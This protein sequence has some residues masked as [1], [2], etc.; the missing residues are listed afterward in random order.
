M[1]ISVNAPSYRR[2]DDV[3]TLSYL[4][5]TRI[6][7]D[8]KEYEAYKEN[9]PDAEIIR[10]P[11]GVQGNVSRVRNYIL[12]EELKR[13]MDVVCIVDDDLYSLIRYEYDEAGS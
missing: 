6:W 8:C 5:F 2:A 9:Y 3:K 10:C 1:R 11:E 12:D 13:G 7:V 4:P